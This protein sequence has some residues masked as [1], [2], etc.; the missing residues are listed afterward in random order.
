MCYK[1]YALMKI[2]KAYNTI[3]SKWEPSH[4]PRSPGGKCAHRGDHRV[5][6]LPSFDFQRQCLTC[7]G[8]VSLKN[9][10]YDFLPKQ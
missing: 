8:F 3:N 5:I 1:M 7:W 9:P 4:S 2:F 6:K 10:K